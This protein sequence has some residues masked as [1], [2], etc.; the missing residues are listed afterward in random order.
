MIEVDK[1]TQ[2][3]VDKVV[4]ECLDDEYIED[5]L[6]YDM[7]SLFAKYFWNEEET[8]IFNRSKKAFLK[9]T[10]NKINNSIDKHLGENNDNR[11]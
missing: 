6:F 5:S 11:E 7:G 3:I 10:E 1:K 4:K 8:K 9:H 2:Q